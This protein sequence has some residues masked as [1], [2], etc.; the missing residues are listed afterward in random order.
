LVAD[1]RE[2]DDE[3]D[4]VR[5]EQ[6]RRFKGQ[7]L[8]SL[9]RVRGE[10]RERSLRGGRVKSRHRAV[11]ALAHCVQERENFFAA[12]LADDHSVW[13]HPKRPTDKLREAHSA[14]ALEV[15]LASLQRDDVGV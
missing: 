12:C 13:R 6:I 1:L 8:G 3:I 2:V 11:I 4:G 14:L 9:D 5:D 7:T 10:L 15:R